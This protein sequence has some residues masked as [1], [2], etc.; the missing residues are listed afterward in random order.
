VRSS[1]EE[2]IETN[3]MVQ[4]KFNL[5]FLF[6]SYNIF[7][8]EK[9]GARATCSPS[10]LSLPPERRLCPLSQVHSI[11]PELATRATYSVPM[12]ILFFT[13]WFIGQ[14]CNVFHPLLAFPIP[15]AGADSLILSRHFLAFIKWPHLCK[16]FG[17]YYFLNHI[18]N[19]HFVCITLFVLILSIK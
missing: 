12:V 19:F 11:L 2:F 7:L 17:Q 15:H 5:G 3:S 10:L 9:S 1:F 14:Q 13:V 18:T 8:R 16:S 6:V 4:S